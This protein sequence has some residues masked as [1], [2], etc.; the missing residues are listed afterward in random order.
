MTNQLKTT[1]EMH[2]W[3]NYDA[4]VQGAEKYY[5]DSQFMF[6]TDHVG[7]MGVWI[8]VSEDLRESDLEDVQRMK[9]IVGR[10]LHLEF[11][12]SLAQFWRS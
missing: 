4:V 3:N 11:A 2:C 1:Y 9:N 10:G 5:I 12:K 6:E 7:W 8:N